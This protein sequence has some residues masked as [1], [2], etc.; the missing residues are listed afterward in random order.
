MASHRATIDADGASETIAAR[1][2]QRNV[3]NKGTGNDRT[4]RAL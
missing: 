4:Q 1:I 3:Q 2:G